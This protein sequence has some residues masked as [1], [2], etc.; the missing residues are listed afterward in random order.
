MYITHFLQEDLDE[1][2]ELLGPD[3]V[4]LGS[5]Y[6]HP[7]GAAEP[8]LFLD[9]LNGLPDETVRAYMRGTTARLL[10]LEA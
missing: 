6:P 10:G 9:K 7:E 1:A 4:V 2:F 5:D 3:H 8:G